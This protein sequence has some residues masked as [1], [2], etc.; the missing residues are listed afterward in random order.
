[1]GD[2]EGPFNAAPPSSEVQEKQENEEI[3]VL[4][5]SFGPPKEALSPRCIWKRQ[6]KL[7]YSLLMSGQ[8]R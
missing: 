7:K 6:E 8:G 5:L 3:A 2:G 1:M 4:P